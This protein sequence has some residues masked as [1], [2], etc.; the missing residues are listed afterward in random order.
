MVIAGMAIFPGP[1]AG[2]DPM[3]QSCAANAPRSARTFDV[4]KHR[5]WQQWTHERAG[6]AKHQAKTR[7]QKF[8]SERSRI[9]YHMNAQLRE[10]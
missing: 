7:R 4:Q 1:L 6:C 2:P 10:S 9:G 8:E 3:G 5:Q